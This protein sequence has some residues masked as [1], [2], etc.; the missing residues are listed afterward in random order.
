MLCWYFSRIQKYLFKLTSLSDSFRLFQQR[1]FTREYVLGKNYSRE[2]LNVKIPRSKLF[3]GEHLFPKMSTYLLVNMYWRSSYFSVNNYWR[4]LFPG[5][6]LLTVTPVF[7]ALLQVTLV[8][9][10]LL[11]AKLLRSCYIK[12]PFKFISWSFKKP[13]I[14]VKTSHYNQ[15]LIAKTQKTLTS[16]I[17]RFKQMIP[18]VN[19]TS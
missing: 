10:L 12:K 5:K 2:Y 4:V 1:G 19:R 15:I 3:E 14:E 11:A 13:Q 16:T 7:F 8:R 17:A 6:Y 18:P 9:C